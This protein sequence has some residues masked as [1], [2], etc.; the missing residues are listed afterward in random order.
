[1]AYLGPGG[2]WVFLTVAFLFPNDIIN[3]L[4]ALHS[5]EERISSGWKAETGKRR[6][7][8]SKPKRYL[9]KLF[10]EI[11]FSSYLFFMAPIV[12]GWGVYD[13]LDPIY[14][15][16]A[17]LLRINYKDCPLGVQLFLYLFIVLWWSWV[18]ALQV[19][20]ISFYVLCSGISVYFHSL[21][22]LKRDYDVLSK[23]A[24]SDSD[25]EIY[26]NL[27]KQFQILLENVRPLLSSVTFLLV[28]GVSG[29]VIMGLYVTISMYSVLE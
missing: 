18:V 6:M 21:W 7:Q 5:L 25:L 15:F 14:F 3:V 28:F 22:L 16:L 24:K 1:M 23:R 17:G 12:V 19:L 2:A 26:I 8:L 4:N 13:H 10:I 20:L 9:I 27:F 29:A 11:L